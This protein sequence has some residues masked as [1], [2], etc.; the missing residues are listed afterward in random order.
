VA[1]LGLPDLPPLFDDAPPEEDAWDGVD[2]RPRHR[3]G[4]PDDF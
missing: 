2:A 4:W 3:M 1:R